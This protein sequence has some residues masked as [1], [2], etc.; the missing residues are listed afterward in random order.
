M[1]VSSARLFAPAFKSLTE[2]CG[3][4]IQ[5]ALC[6]ERQPTRFVESK[7]D[8]LYREFI[9]SWCL[10]TKNELKIPRLTTIE[11]K[12]THKILPSKEDT[13]KNLPS[14]EEDNSEPTGELEALLASEIKWTPRRRGKKVAQK[15]EIVQSK[16]NID[17]DVRNI[18]R[19][20]TEWLFLAVKYRNS[21]WML[22]TADLYHEDSLRQTLQRICREQLGEAYEPYFLG[23]SPCLHRTLVFT[24]NN[25]YSDILGNKI[26]Y[27]RARHIPGTELKIYPQGNDLVDYAWCTIHELE[28]RI[29]NPSLIQ[30]LPLLKYGSQ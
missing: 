23:N 12:I 14:Q 30:S 29:K 7:V 5:I 17:E 27:F 18:E 6:L 9:E 10:G 24:S 4:K 1:R 11:S 22:P 13:A 25:Q 15:D 16:V 26:F 20:A 2:H 8:V 28:S 19:L 3:W 21:G